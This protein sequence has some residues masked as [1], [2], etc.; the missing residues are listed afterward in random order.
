MNIFRYLRSSFSARLSLWVTGFVT[1]IFVVALTLLFRFSLTV[2]KEESLEQNMQVL[3][4]AALRVDRILH[5]TEMTAKTAGWMIHQHLAQ[6]SVI[7]GLC[8][9]VMRSNPGIDSCFVMPVEAQEAET[10]RWQEP[11][12]DT[13]SDSV[14]LRPMM[15]TYTLPGIDG[16][17]RPCL[18]L[19][20]EVRI[21][22]PEIHSE[23]MAQIPYG[24]CFLQGVGGLY[25]QETNGYRPL[26][27][28]GKDVYHYYRS[29]RNT[30]WGMAMLCPE[31]DIMA[32]YN[33]LQATGIV[34]M[35]VV[36]LLLLLLCRLVINNNL[37]SLDLLSVKVHRISQNYFDEPIPTNN[38]L[39]EIGELQ[40]S[41]STMQQSL[42]SHLSEMHQK[43]EALQE[44]NQALQ[45]A[46]DRGR[47]DE[48][49]KTAFLSRISEELMQPVNEINAATDRLGADYQ[50]LTKAE[51]SA[52]Q[53]Q[54][55]TQSETITN[56]IDQTLI[57]SKEK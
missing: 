47:E 15:M 54:I 35:V 52:L 14:A 1:A 49:T 53:Q 57:K 7:Q 27:L 40:R 33:R 48:R 41:F 56:L 29:F 43:T 46:Y 38:R 28:D 9:E 4:H 44:R 10:A 26:K 23:L 25:R 39:D 6:P 32:D 34:V 45:A 36:L 50:R 37:D 5:Q 3:E 31:C 16:E 11:L 13:V 2:V 18:T 24:Q 51:M 20:V 21:D 19:A 22:L 42:A 17:G 30:D 55:N 12:L 8:Q